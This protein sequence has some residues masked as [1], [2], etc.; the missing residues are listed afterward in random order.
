MQPY[1]VDF[2]HCMHPFMDVFNFFL[3]FSHDLLIDFLYN[4]NNNQSKKNTIHIARTHTL[5]MQLSSINLNTEKEEASGIV[6][7]DRPEEDK[8][9]W[10]LSEYVW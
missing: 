3:S 6:I 8:L 2:I 9:L 5:A 10:N 7:Y 1:L 4:S